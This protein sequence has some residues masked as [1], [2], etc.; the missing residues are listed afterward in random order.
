ML[1][2]TEQDAVAIIRTTLHEPVRTVT[3]FNT[4][5]CH[6]VYDIL[7]AS[8]TA[9]VVRIA[10]SDTAAGLAGAMYWSHRL[11]PLGAPLPRILY[12]DVQSQ[13]TPFAFLLLER[14]P[15]TDIGHVYP[16]LSTQDKRSIVTER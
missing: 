12:A 11:R 14:L 1:T 6:Y 15:G 9:V 7:T 16:Q 2:P 4:G 13:S 5:L 8:N 3:R 10:R